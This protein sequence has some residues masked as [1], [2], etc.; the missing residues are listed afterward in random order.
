[1]NIWQDIY[2]TALMALVV[3]ILLGMALLLAPKIRRQYTYQDKIDQLEEDIR[4]QSEYLNKLRVNQERF[5]SDPEFVERVA[6]EKGRART[7]EVLF[8]FP[9]HE[10]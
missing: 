4:Q 6:H 7:N 3:L 2:K 8:T 5:K 1:M 9:G 10:D